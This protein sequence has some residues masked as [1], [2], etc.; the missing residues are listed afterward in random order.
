MKEIRE[1]SEL[2]DIKSVENAEQC[3]ALCC[4]L[5]SKCVTWQYQKA[6]KECKVGGPVRLGLESADTHDWCEPKAPEIWKGKKIKSKGEGTCTWS[7]NLPH[8]C[9]GLGPERMG[10]D[11]QSIKD[12]SECEM[13]CC[14]DAECEMYQYM[15]GRGCFYAS[16]NG[17]WCEEKQLNAYEGSR[18]CIKGFCGDLESQML[19]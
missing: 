13:E 1:F 5:D 3:R 11:G 17:I 12:A 15:K 8:Q 18:K 14:K 10:K 2:K 19:K 16:S 4:N 7:E 6:T 9:F